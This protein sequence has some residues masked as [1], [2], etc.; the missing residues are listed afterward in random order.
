MSNPIRLTALVL[1]FCLVSTT[2]V[3]A[4]HSDYFNEIFTKIQRQIKSGDLEA[5]QI[6]AI[7]KLR[8]EFNR[9]KS[10]DHTERHLS[11]SAHDKHVPTFIAAAAGV[12]NDTQFEK[13]T[14]KKKTEVQKLRYEVNQ[15][16]KELKEIRALLDGMKASK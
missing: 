15:L 16:Q 6:A 7:W 3:M 2:S 1:A 12:L 9:Q 5:D 11:C 13:A 4:C 8:D 14:G 10:L